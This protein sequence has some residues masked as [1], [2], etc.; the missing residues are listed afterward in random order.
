M[1]RLTQ[2]WQRDDGVLTFEWVLLITV[3][4]IGVVGGLSSVRDAIISE[5]GD[6][7]AAAVAI[8]Q[9]YTVGPDPVFEAGGFSFE[10]TS[11]NLAV[12]E[13]PADPVITQP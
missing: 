4:V 6:L 5:L 2:F 11:C 9:S 1:P 12:T 10:D 13:R 7:A 8:D 3:V